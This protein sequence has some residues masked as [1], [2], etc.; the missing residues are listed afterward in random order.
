MECVDRCGVPCTSVETSRAF[1]VAFRSTAKPGDM[2]P[3]TRAAAI[4]TLAI[5]VSMIVTPDVF[6]SGGVGSQYAGNVRGDRDYIVKIAADA[7]SMV[8]RL[9]R[10]D[11]ILIS[12]PDLV[13]SKRAAIRFINLKTAKAL[14]LD[15]PPKL[16]ALADKVIE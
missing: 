10:D 9:V 6:R 14:G 12:R 5:F 15:P 3:M 1:F 4:T 2:A 16:L 7:L 11:R 8:L 13:T